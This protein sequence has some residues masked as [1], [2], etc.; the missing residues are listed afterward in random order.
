ML[1]TRTP[2]DNL[3]HRHIRR[4]M[5]PDSDPACALHHDEQLAGRRGVHSQDR[6]G[7]EAHPADGGLTAAARDP[8][9][10]GT[11][12]TELGDRAFIAGVEYLHLAQANNP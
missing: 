2:H 9:P 10:M 4:W 6:T 12:T 3:A 1:L 11:T 7:F 5:I 8:S